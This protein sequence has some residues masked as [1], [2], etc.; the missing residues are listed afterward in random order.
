M[1]MCFQSH[2]VDLVARLEKLQDLANNGKGIGKDGRYF[3]I[4]DL[5]YRM[6]FDS[7]GEIA[8]GISVGCLKQV[9]ADVHARARY[10]LYVFRG[11]WDRKASLWPPPSTRL[12]STARNDSSTRCGGRGRTASCSPT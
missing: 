7:I 11:V 5:F 1:T 9:C 2:C 4:Q 3:D 10:L 12:K 8:F 6:T